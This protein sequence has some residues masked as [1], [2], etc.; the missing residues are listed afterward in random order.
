VRSVR[1]LFL[2]YF[3]STRC[4]RKG[5][6]GPVVDDN[7]SFLGVVKIILCCIFMVAECGGGPGDWKA[8]GKLGRLGVV[9]WGDG[10]Y[11]LYGRD[12]LNGLDWRR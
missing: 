12:G 6:L 8:V 2:F 11:G 9:E 10:L 1:Q 7:A 5:L 3:L 4:G